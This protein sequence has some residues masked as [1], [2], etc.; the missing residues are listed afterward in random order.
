MMMKL[1]ILPCAEKLGSLFS[2]PHRKHELKPTNCFLSVSKTA[3]NTRSLDT[4]CR[5]DDFKHRDTAVKLS[6]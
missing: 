2:L 6:W 5:L 4:Y 1:P 3:R